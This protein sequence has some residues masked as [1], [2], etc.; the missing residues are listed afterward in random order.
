MIE[1]DCNYPDCM[2]CFERSAKAEMEYTGSSGDKEMYYEWM[3]IKGAESVE[4]HTLA[5]YSPEALEEI[6]KNPNEW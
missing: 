2:A 5:D 6:I 3:D 1:C 4:E